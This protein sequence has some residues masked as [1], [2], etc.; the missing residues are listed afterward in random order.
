MSEIADL[1]QSIEN[2]YADQG[3]AHLLRPGARVEEVDAL[4]ALMGLPLPAELRESLLRHDGSSDSGWVHGDLLSIDG[5]KRERAIWMGLL[6]EGTFDELADFNAENP[7]VQAGH[8]HPGWLPLDADGGGNGA[9]VDLSLGYAGQVR[10]M[11]HEVGPSA[12]AHTLTGY[13][14]AVL[15]ALESGE[16]RYYR[17]AE[18]DFEGICTLDE[19]EDFEDED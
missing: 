17:H 2:W 11:D 13:L 19:I 1:W 12:E 5:M 18:D 16:Y 4:E 10:D 8:W 15:S 3:A 6:Q 7:A 9:F 14:Q